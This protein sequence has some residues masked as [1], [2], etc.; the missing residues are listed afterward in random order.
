MRSSRLVCEKVS[1]ALR[2]GLDGLVDVGGRAGG[3]VAGDFFGR[4]VDHV[5]GLGR[6]RVDPLRRRCR[7]S[8][9]R[10]CRAPWPRP[11]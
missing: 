6:H 9:I 10:A 8:C 11:T 2:G 1:N 3:D 7:T 5:E 4:R